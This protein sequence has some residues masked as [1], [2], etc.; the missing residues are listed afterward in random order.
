V[1]AALELPQV[2]QLLLLDLCHLQARDSLW[3]PLL[4]LLLLLVRL[5]NSRQSWWHCL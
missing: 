1:T 4:L 2:L 3:A 5:C